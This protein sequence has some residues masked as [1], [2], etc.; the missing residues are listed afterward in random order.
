MG[1]EENPKNR[2]TTESEAFH[3]RTVNQVNEFSNKNSANPEL[4]EQ[5]LKNWEKSMRERRVFKYGYL[6]ILHYLFCW[7]ICRRKR[8]LSKKPKFR[9]HLYFEVG[10][11]KLLDELDWVTIIKSIRKLEILTQILLNKRQKFMMK[12]QRN[13]VIDSSSSGTSDEGQLNIVDLMKSK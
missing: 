12:F 10:H 4:K 11:E 9:D 7:V 13:N 1:N 6:D 8:T 2:P 3:K 5:I